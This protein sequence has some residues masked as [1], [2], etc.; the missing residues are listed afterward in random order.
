MVVTD[1]L[2]LQERPRRAHRDAARSQGLEESAH[3]R[4]HVR[5]GVWFGMNLNQPSILPLEP[6]HLQVC[7]A[8]YEKLEEEWPVDEETEQEKQ[9]CL[10]CEAPPLA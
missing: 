7:M 4:A 6:A 3:R 8:C 9:Y 2:C 10:M 1:T 5:D